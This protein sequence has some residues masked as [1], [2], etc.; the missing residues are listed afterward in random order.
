MR[1]ETAEVIRRRI[2]RAT[3]AVGVLGITAIIG[4]SAASQY[5]IEIDIVPPDVSSVDEVEKNER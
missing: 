1:P 2:T 5:P 4:L 3:D